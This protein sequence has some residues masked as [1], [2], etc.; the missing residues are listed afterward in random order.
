[1]E[2]KKIVKAVFKKIKMEKVNE[3]FSF[4]R[5]GRKYNAQS[6][7]DMAHQLDDT[8]WHEEGYLS[9]QVRFENG[10]LEYYTCSGRTIK[11]I[12]S[13]TGAGGEFHLEVDFG[14]GSSLFYQDIVDI[15]GE[16]DERKGE[17]G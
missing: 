14:K 12:S 9:S 1:M 4:I 8:T 13:Q 2:D 11:I 16:P 7:E 15:L 17:R 3:L 5:V 10:A 6:L